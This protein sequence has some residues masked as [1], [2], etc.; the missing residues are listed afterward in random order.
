MT[1]AMKLIIQSIPEKSHRERCAPIY[2]MSM[3]VNSH[4]HQL[5]E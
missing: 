3:N 2:T 4:I 1:Y 5:S